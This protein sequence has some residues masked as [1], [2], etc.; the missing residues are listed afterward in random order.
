MTQ[1]D[2]DG[3]LA[4]LRR[5]FNQL[6]RCE[7]EDIFEPDHDLLF[8]VLNW[9]GVVMNQRAKGMLLDL[10]KLPRS[11][12]DF[13]DLSW[14]FSQGPHNKGRILMQLDEAAY[15]YGVVQEVQDGL[16]MEVGRALGGSTLLLAAGMKPGCRLVSIDR[17]DVCD[18]AVL[19]VLTRWGLSEQVELVIESYSIPRIDNPI[20]LLFVDGDHSYAGVRSDYDRWRDHL[21]VGGHLLFH[22]ASIVRDFAE[23]QVGPMGLVAQITALERARFERIAT[24]GSLVHFRRVT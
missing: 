9:V 18:L 20:A 13:T 16:I 22:N 14:L 19:S 5:A 2:R 8:T 10:D 6:A 3:N 11:V 21:R 7:G 17:R 1:L 24:V 4:E 15:L 23:G 12:Q